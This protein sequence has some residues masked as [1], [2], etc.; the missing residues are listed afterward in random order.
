MHVEKKGWL[1][2]RGA[3]VRNW[4]RRWFVLTQH[5]LV[6]FDSPQ[7]KR[8]KGAIELKYC[9]L[10]SNNTDSITGKEYSFILKERSACCGGTDRDW[11]IRG[12]NEEERKSWI[13]SLTLSFSQWEHEG[14]EKLLVLL[15][16]EG[17]ISSREGRGRESSELAKSLGSDS[18]QRDHE[19]SVKIVRMGETEK[20]DK[21]VH[22]IE[23]YIGEDQEKEKTVE[24]QEGEEKEKKI[25]TEKEGGEPEGEERKGKKG[26]RVN[27]NKYSILMWEKKLAGISSTWISDTERYKL[28]GVR[29]ETL[30]ERERQLG[31]PINEDSIPTIASILMDHV[32]KFGA[33]EKGIFRIPGSQDDMNFL[34]QKWET[35]EKVSLSQYAAC[36]D[37][38]NIAGLLKMFI[39]ELPDPLL[40]HDAYPMLIL[41]QKQEG[42][43]DRRLGFEQ[44]IKLLPP[45]HRALLRRLLRMLH[46]LL[47]HAHVTEMTSNNLAIVFAPNLL[48]SERGDLLTTMRDAPYTMSITRYLIDH[49]LDLFPESD[50]NSSTNTEVQ[51]VEEGKNLSEEKTSEPTEV[52][53]QRPKDKETSVTALS[54]ES[55]K[56]KEEIK[57]IAE[58]EETKKIEETNLEKENGKS[59]VI[60]QE[61]DINE[62]KFNPEVSIKE[63]GNIAAEDETGLEN[64]TKEERH[65]EHLAGVTAEIETIKQEKPEQ[66]EARNKDHP[67]KGDVEITT[68]EKVLDEAEKVANDA[69]E[70]VRVIFR[71]ASSS[72]QR[73]DIDWVRGGVRDRGVTESVHLTVSDDMDRHSE[74][75]GEGPS[76][77]EPRLKGSRERGGGIDFNFIKKRCGTARDAKTKPK[78]TVATEEPVDVGKAEETSEEHVEA[79]KTDV[80]DNPQDRKNEGESTKD[81]GDGDGDCDG[82]CDGCDGDEEA[83]TTIQDQ[84]EGEVQLHNGE[85][86]NATNKEETLLDMLKKNEED[87][88]NLLKEVNDV[89]SA[90]S[91]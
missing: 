47:V 9:T 50:S 39:R 11:W 42:E 87:V 23:G 40:T 22:I 43:D 31:R 14:K 5:S 10:Q 79:E 82:G 67:Q 46:N 64:T 45:S 19:A 6:Y 37:I 72:K 68:I 62:V 85:P 53:L 76:R 30:L 36:K 49:Y 8:P 38:H 24:Q 2:K 41:T 54:Q 60:E 65:E 32:E 71:S 75:D 51:E 28:F 35:G 77:R 52:V 57:N 1:H 63:K 61:S 74:S 44:I 91:P 18:T 16:E 86:E 29:L 73:R 33:K 78:V 12:E 80:K 20:E 89:L 15:S 25:Q 90:G 56:S 26:K 4:R 58:T 83:Q 27:K 55:E 7:A 88:S 66:W 59:E 21:G 84:G 13:S 48:K 34:R 81:S 70:Q 17:D 69:G 3:V